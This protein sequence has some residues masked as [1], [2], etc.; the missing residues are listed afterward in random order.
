MANLVP[1]VV[2]EGVA[3]LIEQNGQDPVELF[4]RVGI[5]E[6]AILE[7]NVLIR[8]ERYADLLELAAIE[9]SDRFFGLKVGCLQRFDIMGNLWL[10]ARQ[11][12]TI[13]E[14]MQLICENLA[15]H[16]DTMTSY[17]SNDGTSGKLMSFEFKTPV[18]PQSRK[19]PLPWSHVQASE[20]I[21]SLTCNEFRRS[22]GHD[23]MPDYVQFRHAAP[24]K[25]KTPLYKVFGH[26]VF[27]N[28]DVHAIHLTNEDF[29]Q[30]NTQGPGSEAA[31]EIHKKNTR[32][33]QSTFG[34]GESFIGRVNRI[35]RLLVNDE[36]C[37]ASDVAHLVDL[38]ERTLRYRLKKYNTSYQALYD[39][40]RLEIAQN[41][42][43]NSELAVNAI[44]ERLHF[45]NTSSFSS[46][47]KRQT[48]QSPRNFVKILGALERRLA[49]S[50]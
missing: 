20:L 50:G 41:Y 29:S 47:F 4:R 38:P 25:D 7:P 9:C 44:A 16:T 2:L 27:F 23:W 31:T 46:F 12:E 18:N 19:K 22:L 3:E 26:R 43:I 1:S 34:L 14:E 42:L 10:M 11:A 13:G 8:P 48:G 30:P 36:G 39:K 49:A 15:L 24:A 17:I 35:I 32:A 40:A 45:T 28:Q 6:A 21:L 37:T 5:P 33:F